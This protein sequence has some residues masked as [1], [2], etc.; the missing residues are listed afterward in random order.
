MA[1]KPKGRLWE[2]MEDYAVGTPPASYRSTP[3]VYF[4]VNGISNC[5]YYYAIGSIGFALA[6]FMMG[7]VATLIAG[8]VIATFGWWMAR[9]QWR[10]G[11]TYE[12]QSRFFGWGHWGSVIPALACALLLWSFYVMEMYWMGAAFAY[13]WKVNIWSIYVP[14]AVVI[15][16]LVVFGHK[17]I[18]W[19]S[20][21]AI[22]IGV[23]AAI[24]I[25]VK[26][27][28]SPEFSWAD[29]YAF[30]AKPIIPGG[31]AGA[32]GF[33][34][35]AVGLVIG[36]TFGNYGRFTKTPTQA[37]WLGP[38]YLIIA[39][40]AMPLIGF[41]LTFPLIITLTPVVGAEQAGMMAFETSVP[42]VVAFG[43]L[44]I[45]VVLGWQMNVQYVNVHLPSLSLAAIYQAATRRSVPRWVW[46]IVCSIIP[47]LM[48]WGGLFGIMVE[49][50]TWTGAALLGTVV[51]FPADYLWRRWNGY[52]TEFAFKEIRGVNPVA[53][54]TYF[55]GFAIGIVLW[56]FPQP[57][58]IAPIPSIIGPAATFLLY[59]LGCWITKGKYQ[60]PVGA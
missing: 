40:I 9:F 13:I 57:A 51:I 50:A 15:G 28:L 10:S 45:I 18:G 59:W 56:K 53:I 41:L 35:M 12:F 33:A 38:T 26:L 2:M 52:P 44:G 32:L 22:P 42:F 58:G 7:W 47:M 16:L 36:P 30:A 3:E 60:K 5:L 31:F 27:Y 23:G 25:I 6:G 37:S 55:V 54:V 39:H 8:V 43:A 1:E 20:Y 48:L 34:M 14:L 29:T 21:A 4:T 19:W 17:V 11:Y 24:Y 49:W 46:V